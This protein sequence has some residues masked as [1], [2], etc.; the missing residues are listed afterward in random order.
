MEEKEFVR[1]VREV[2]GRVAIVGGWVRDFIRGAEAKDKD[3]VVAGLD[4][5][6]FGDL[7]PDAQKVGRSFP[8]FL[9]KIGGVSSE[10]ALART[11]RK[12]GTGYLGFTSCS[13]KSVTL[14]DDLSRRDTT[15][16]A[17]ALELFSDGALPK[18]IDLFGGEADVRFR[19]IRA[20]SERF[21]EDP[22]RAL[23]AAR[24]AAAFGFSVEPRT[25]DLMAACRDELAREPQPRIFGEFSLALAA[26][27]PSV[28]FRTLLTARLLDA[29]FPEISALIG[30]TQPEAFHPEGDAFEHTMATVDAVAE[31]T[32]NLIV[33][34]AAL[35]HDL[36]KG[37]TPESILPHHY[38]HE[39]RGLDVL[40]G[41]NRRM[42]MPRIW[43]Q[44]AEFV[45]AQHMRASRLKKPGKIA[46]LLVALSRLPVPAKDVLHVFCVDH[47]G[48][49]PYFE[50]YDSL[51]KELLSVRGGDAP[52]E[53][54]GEDVGAWIRKQRAG[55]IR[56][57]AR[58]WRQEGEA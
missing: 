36:G 10:V 14:E 57:A 47:G 31:R 15:M 42:Q 35:A 19:K 7:F 43:L 21:L 1:K 18:R 56:I 46:D 44:V 25:I 5:A 49:P 45:I 27:R 12:T 11:E 3:Y 33:R 34:F 6:S 9:L 37:T 4:E 32:E 20:V 26:R 24:Q 54:S 2:G 41:W 40:A 23:R 50:H 58:Q 17:M 29:I 30:K 48:L 38:G 55:R 16:N 28:F 22:V 53:L 8:V 13:D 39:R 52:K 51:I